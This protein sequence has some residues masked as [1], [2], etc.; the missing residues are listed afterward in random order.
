MLTLTGRS[1]VLSVVTQQRG[2]KKLYR[3]QKIINEGKQSSVSHSFDVIAL[4]HYSKLSRRAQ[5]RPLTEP[6]G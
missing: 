6:R 5:V 2:N 3:P 4:S 1:D